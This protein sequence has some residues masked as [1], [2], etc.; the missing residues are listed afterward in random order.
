MDRLENQNSFHDVEWIKT[1]LLDSLIS[2]Y[3][4]Y[5]N[6]FHDVEWIKTNSGLSGVARL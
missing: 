6:S 3:S 1:A 4:A 5:Q 2:V